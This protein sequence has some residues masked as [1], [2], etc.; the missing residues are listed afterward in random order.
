MFFLFR[1]QVVLV[2]ILSGIGIITLTRGDDESQLQLQQC[3]ATYSIDS[4]YYNSSIKIGGSASYYYTD[5]YSSIGMAI[6]QGWDLFANW[7]NVEKQ[8]KS[9]E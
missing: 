9:S 7:L 8:G 3:K 2:L 1:S 4:S 5:F 6:T